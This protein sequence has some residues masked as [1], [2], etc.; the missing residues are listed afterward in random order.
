M[1][2]NGGRRPKMGQKL[3]KQQNIE[4]AYFVPV[5][6]WSENPDLMTW[7]VRA[8]CEHVLMEH[9]QATPQGWDLEIFK[10]G[11]P[12]DD[13]GN[14]LS[15][16]VVRVVCKGARTIEEKVK[17]PLLGIDGRPIGGV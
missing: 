14:I 12:L 1:S 6:L 7:D 5:K 13:R 10:A 9:Y 11:E 17:T 16:D 15:Y 8:K 2:K 3:R 4:T